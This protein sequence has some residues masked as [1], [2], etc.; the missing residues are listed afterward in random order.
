MKVLTLINLLGDRYQYSYSG[1]LNEE[2]YSVQLVTR[3]QIS[4]PNILYIA[5]NLT[6]IVMTQNTCLLH[7]KEEDVP[8][9]AERLLDI[10]MKDYQRSN[11]LA[12]MGALISEKAPITE[13]SDIA[14]KIMENP[15]CFLTTNFQ[16]TAASGTSEVIE[17]MIVQKNLQNKM[18]SSDKDFILL[19]KDKTYSCQRMLVPVYYNDNLNGYFYVVASDRPF[20]L[21]TDEYYA[22]QIGRLMQLRSSLKPMPLMM[23]EEQKLMVDL[24]EGSIEDTELLDR[25]MK[26][27]GWTNSS[28]YYLLSVDLEGNIQN[29][30][31]I[32]E[33]SCLIH[34]NVYEYKKH[35]VVL[36]GEELIQRQEEEN[37]ST[38]IEYLKEKCLYAGVSYGFSNLQF[39]SNAYAQSLYAIILRKSLTNKVYLSFYGDLVG[40]HMYYLLDAF[41][42]DISIFCDPTA[43]QIVEYDKEHGTQYLNSLVVYICLNCGLQ[44]AAD[45]LHVHK[46]TLLKHIKVFEERF[47]IDFNNHR[48]VNN[49]RRTMEVFSFLGT[50]DVQKL[51]GNEQ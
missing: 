27:M 51:L 47:H 2:I 25:K 20:M 31:I 12:K 45:T 38:L 19:D 17:N 3:G 40:N 46:N 8:E 23:S 49:L 7:L 39:T 48:K 6:D 1:P 24:L 14:Y 41:G 44:Q 33:L 9:I 22:R 13:L 29:K 30:K 37:W 4:C 34:T 11:T 42:I 32:E 10:V 43:L 21:E 15:I 28:M 50:I 26:H 16:V 18:I 36:L 35:A 5:H